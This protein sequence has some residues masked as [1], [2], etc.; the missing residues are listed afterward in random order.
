MKRRNHE[1]VY[2]SSTRSSPRGKRLLSWLLSIVMLLSLLPGMEL[3]VHAGYEDGAEC[4]ACGHY[5]WDDYMCGICGACSENC[6]Q[7]DC[8]LENHPCPY[9]DRCIL[10]YGDDFFCD[11]CG[12]CF[13][14]VDSNEDSGEHCQICL[15]EDVYCS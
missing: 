12:T 2:T 14:C 11:S 7:T 8:W 6:T 5:H 10:D 3:H 13:H 1:E 15:A 9:C 4:P